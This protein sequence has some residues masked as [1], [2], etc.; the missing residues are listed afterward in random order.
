[1]AYIAAS[2]G[3]CHCKACW[4]LADVPHGTLGGVFTVRAMRDDGYE[5]HVLQSGFLTKASA[6]A[7]FETT[8]TTKGGR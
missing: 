1:M 6:K 3:C 4:N 2:N 7:A 8:A 5:Y